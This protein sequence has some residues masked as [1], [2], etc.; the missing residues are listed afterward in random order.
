M[1]AR[2]VQ[3]RSGP[4]LTLR[5]WGSPEGRPL[6][7]VHHL[8]MTASGARM[9]A[10]GPLL[11]ER[12]WRV[13]APD[14]PGFGESPEL[15][16][17]EYAP[18]VLSGLLLEL[19]DAEEIE[20]AAWVG[21]SWG[22]TLGIHAAAWNAPR[23]TALALLDVGYQ[24][25]MPRE[26]YDEILAS[27][28]GIERP[29]ASYDEAVG[30]VSEHSPRWSD[31][32]AGELRSRLVERGGQLFLPTRSG[33]AAA[34]SYGI[35]EHAPSR[36]LPQVAASGL[37]VL[38]LAASEPPDEGRA[39]LLERFVEAVPQAEVRVVPDVTHDLVLDLGAGLAPLLDGW[40]DAAA[41]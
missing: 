17:D 30:W 40:L 2:V 5:E 31:A 11:A 18:P 10:P 27:M 9:D 4:Q 26:P 36:V 21:H 41:R 20:R 3:L 38:L 12:G 16:P 37:P 8:G 33:A 1:S 22:G 28:R 19:L 32:A 23:L 35:R 15:P 7:F 6:L 39:A 25:D 14:L 34:A 29:F 13:L 24:E